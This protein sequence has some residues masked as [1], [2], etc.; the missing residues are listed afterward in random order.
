[1]A[2]WTLFPADLNVIPTRRSIQAEQTN[3]ES[4]PGV[5]D[6]LNLEAVAGFTV[7]FVCAEGE[8]F[9]SATTLFK[10]FRYD[11]RVGGLPVRSAE[12]DVTVGADGVGFRGIAA[13]F[14]VASPRGRVCH[15]WDG[16]GVTGGNVTVTYTASMLVGVRA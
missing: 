4:D 6:G 10:A 3:A 11:E 5:D 13:A 9:N 12:H 7:Y 2:V 8:A 16:T 1:M 15:I 14:S